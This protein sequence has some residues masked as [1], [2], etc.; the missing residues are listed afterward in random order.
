MTNLDNSSLNNHMK[1]VIAEMQQNLHQANQVIQH[2]LVQS[3]QL[4]EHIGQQEV[5]QAQAQQHLGGANHSDPVSQAQQFVGQVNNALHQS[6]ANEVP[7]MQQL[8]QSAMQHIQGTDQAMHQSI[9]S[10]QQAMESQ[11]QAMEQQ[12]LKPNLSHQPVE[13]PQPGN[14]PQ[15][16]VNEGVQPAQEGQHA[17]GQVPGQMPGQPAEQDGI[18]QNANPTNPAAEPPGSIGGA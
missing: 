6:E 2:T 10:M 9:A 18:L 8:K 12:F 11:R 4:M 17:S 16:S 1:N 13:S 15:P 14:S 7:H 5:S 3:Q